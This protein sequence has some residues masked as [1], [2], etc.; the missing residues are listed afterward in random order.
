MP[1]LCYIALN[2]ILLFA[3]VFY[4]F[5]SNLNPT[6]EEEE[7]EWCIDDIMSCFVEFQNQNK[8]RYYNFF[9]LKSTKRSN[10]FHS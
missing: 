7:G 10:V 3:L 6:E 1:I 4:V 2:T 9:D 8:I 5:Q